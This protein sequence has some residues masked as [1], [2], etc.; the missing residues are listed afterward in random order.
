MKVFELIE[1]LKTLPQ[2]YDVAMADYLPI[3]LIYS[4]DEQEK[5]LFSDYI[6]E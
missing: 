6:E 1:K 5:I 4:D 2:N 3:T